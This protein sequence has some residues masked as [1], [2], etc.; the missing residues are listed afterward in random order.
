M[1]HRE[2]PWIILAKPSVLV[3]SEPENVIGWSFVFFSHHKYR[4]CIVVLPI[5][6]S[7]EHNEEQKVLISSFDQGFTVNTTKLVFRGIW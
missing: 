7:V 5:N 3:G 2:G 6:E 1:V 4:G